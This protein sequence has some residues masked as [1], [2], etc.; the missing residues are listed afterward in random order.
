MSKDKE[1]FVFITETSNTNVNKE[2]EKDILKI[3]N[4]ECIGI[5]LDKNNRK[6][7]GSFKPNVEIKNNTVTL[8]Q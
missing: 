4:L 2:V 3:A 6:I 8:K 7:S 5:T 1:N